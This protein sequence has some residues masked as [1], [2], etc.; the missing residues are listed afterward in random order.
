MWNT[1]CYIF[2]KELHVLLKNIRE[3]LNLLYLFFEF[4]VLLVCKQNFSI[5]GTV[6]FIW[7]N[8]LKILILLTVI[9]YLLKRLWLFSRSLMCVGGDGLARDAV[10]ATCHVCNVCSAKAMIVHFAQYSVYPYYG[11]NFVIKKSIC[12]PRFVS[13]TY[14]N[15][16]FP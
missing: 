9:T 10:S 7:W 2:V 16:T 8:S 11:D 12:I 6:I 15:C 14:L 3:Y 5:C 4:A 13:S 1:F